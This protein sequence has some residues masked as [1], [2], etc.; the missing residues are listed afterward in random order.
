[1]PIGPPKRGALGG[2]RPSAGREDP[3]L[4]EDRPRGA[5]QVRQDLVRGARPRFKSSCGAEGLP[6]ACDDVFLWACLGIPQKKEKQN[7]ITYVVVGNQP[8]GYHKI[9]FPHEAS[10]GVGDVDA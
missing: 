10:L 6:G 4:R 3:A 9:H 2:S 7:G 5:A 1:M 8:L